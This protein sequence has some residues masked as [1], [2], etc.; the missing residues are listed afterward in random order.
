MPLFWW[1]WREPL[2][3]AKAVARKAVT[4]ILCFIVWYSFL[5]GHVLSNIR[6]LFG[7]EHE[8]RTHIPDFRGRIRRDL[9]FRSENWALFTIR[10]SASGAG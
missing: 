10:G 7:N 8:H 1:V 5:V 9:Y 2:D 6:G 4:A 3:P